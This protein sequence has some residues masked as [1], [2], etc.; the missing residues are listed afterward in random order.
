LSYFRKKLSRSQ[1]LGT[2]PLGNKTN[3]QN[4][5]ALFSFWVSMARIFFKAYQRL[6]KCK[7]RCKCGR[8]YREL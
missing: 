4:F 3:C 8:R 6:H 2:F 5:F 1:K 7:H